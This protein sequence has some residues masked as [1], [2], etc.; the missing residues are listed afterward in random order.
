MHWILF[1]TVGENFGDCRR[2]GR[3][4]VVHMPDRAHVH[5]RLHGLRFGRVPS[6]N[7][8]GKVAGN[9]KTFTVAPEGVDGQKVFTWDIIFGVVNC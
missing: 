5:V 2:E 8:G 9:S 3:L 6:R 7:R 4:P 1:L